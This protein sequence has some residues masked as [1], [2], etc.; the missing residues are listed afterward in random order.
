LISKKRGELILDYYILGKDEY[1]YRVMINY[2]YED[3]KIIHIIQDCFWS[4]KYKQYCMDELNAKIKKR[5]NGRKV[6][7]FN[8]EKQV[9]KAKEWLESQVLMKKMRIK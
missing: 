9:K 3:Y 8:N 7:Y 4:R 5:E 1:G 2:K 6:I